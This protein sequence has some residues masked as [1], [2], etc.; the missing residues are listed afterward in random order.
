MWILAAIALPIIYVLLAF[1][2]RE[3]RSLSVFFLACVPGSIA[4]FFLGSLIF[5]HTGIEWMPVAH[6]LIGSFVC[7][8]IILEWVNSLNQRQ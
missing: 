2:F 8:K 3:N 1:R 6:S 5:G 7:A 4:G